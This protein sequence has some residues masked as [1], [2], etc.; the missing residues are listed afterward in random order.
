MAILL[1]TNAMRTLEG[2]L[3][4]IIALYEALGVIVGVV[5]THNRE[6]VYSL[7]LFCFVKNVGHVL[8]GRSRRQSR[9]GLDVH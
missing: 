2:D 1:F 9:A 6:R 5:F 8:H 3:W 4:V 7:P